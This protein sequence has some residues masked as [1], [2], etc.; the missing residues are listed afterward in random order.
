MKYDVLIIGGVA[1]GTSVGASAKRLDSSL[2]ILLIQKE[3]Y[4]SYGGCGLP[5]Y[6]Q[7]VIKNINDL[8]EFTP[9]RFREEKGVEVL[10]EHEVFDV[11]FEKK[12]VKA[13]NTNNRKVKE[14]EY[15]KLVITTGASPIL[16]NL[17]GIKNNRI[18]TIRTPDDALKI[19][20]FL[21]EKNPK[22]VVIVGGGYIGV[23]M[24]ETFREHGLRVYIIE[25]L[26][27]LL[28]NAEPEINKIIV[29]SLE[30]NGV[31]VLLKTRVE[32]FISTER[33]KVVTNSG[34]IET[35]MV[36]IAVGVKPNT[37]IFNGIRKG[38][39]GAIEVD[40][41]GK[42]SIK[43]VFS[44]GDCATVNHFIIKK[45]VYIPMGT[46]ANK[47]GRIVGKNVAGGEEKFIGVLGSSITKIFN[48]EFGRT[49]ITEEEAKMFG[50]DPGSVYIKALSKAKYYPKAKPIHIKL[51]FDKKTGK[52]LGAQ[53]VGNDIH[54]RLNTIVSAIYGNLTIEELGYI[55]LAY[56]PPFSPV[57][58]PVLISGNAAKKYLKS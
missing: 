47:Q 1:A 3:R 22:S 8:I 21:K 9:H 39:K 45:K 19:R 32:K 44:A 27:H 48:I 49:G 4:I 34:D 40:E 50:Y 30:K 26:D 38:I 11:N 10:T 36:L 25:M 46:T 37:E 13:R 29:D 5:Y 43:D 53:M 52:I 18:F 31:K 51:F 6:V 16:P 7:G 41:M 15:E 58:D 2:R 28:G 23:E 24:S 35:D 17:E 12:I 55:D 33:I 56:A 14:F 57:W 20:K 54:K 42:T